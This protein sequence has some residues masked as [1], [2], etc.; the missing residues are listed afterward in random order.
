MYVCM[1]VCMYV[2]TGIPVHNIAAACVG[3]L[4]LIVVIV[5][6]IVFCKRKLG[7]I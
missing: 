7:E 6:I 2:S 5:I 4:V 1:Y 3:A